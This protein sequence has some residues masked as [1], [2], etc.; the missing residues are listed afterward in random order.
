MALT[1]DPN[2][3]PSIPFWVFED[4]DGDRWM[5]PGLL[6]VLDHDG[7]ETTYPIDDGAGGPFWIGPDTGMLVF[8][9]D[10]DDG[11]I[12]TGT[13]GP[14]I[15]VAVPP[16]VAPEPGVPGEVYWLVAEVD[17]I[18]PGDWI[19]HLVG[20]VTWNNATPAM[21]DE[22][23]NVIFKDS[24]GTE[25]ARLTFINGRF[26]GTGDLVVDLDPTTTPGS[27]P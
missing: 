1:I 12:S 6:R 9:L 15:E 22:A 20:E 7:S 10:L 24:S 25:A 27:G 2:D 5:T 23:A 16:D 13:T 11:G 4:E 18:A 19:Q 14:S 8:R 26:A 3:V 17:S 21:P